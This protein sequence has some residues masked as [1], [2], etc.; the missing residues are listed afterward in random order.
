MRE[1]TFSRFLWVI[2]K[3]A[4]SIFGIITLII[5]IAL[6]ILTGFLSI[7]NLSK[8]LI[9]GILANVCIILG[10]FAEWRHV[11]PRYSGNNALAFDVRSMDFVPRM[12][13]GSMP[14]R[15]CTFRVE[16]DLQNRA[17]ER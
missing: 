16:F 14:D 4:S 15:K 1:Y 6:S 11:A 13:H 2:L 8:V 17:L 3:R 7:P 10:A 9:M 5:A 12:W